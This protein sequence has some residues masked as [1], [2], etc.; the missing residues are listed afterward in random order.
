MRADHG[1]DLARQFAQR[2][3]LGAEENHV[4][5]AKFSRVCIGLDLYVM[6]SVKV[7]QDD[8]VTA[9]GRQGLASGQHRNLL[10]AFHEKGGE[11]AADGPGTGNADA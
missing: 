3:G 2:R 1:L 4:L 6:P 11:G 7:V 9:D 10:A 5:R 8:A